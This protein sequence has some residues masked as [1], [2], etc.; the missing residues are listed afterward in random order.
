MAQASALVCVVSEQVTEMIKKMHKTNLCSLS[1]YCISVL[2]KGF[3]QE[4]LISSIEIKNVL[5]H[6]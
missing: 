2:L 4:E 5:L 6:A 1:L 3:Q